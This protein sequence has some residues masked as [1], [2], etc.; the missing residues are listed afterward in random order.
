MASA[1]LPPALEDRLA[2]L[3]AR[4]WRL[5]VIRGA[6]RFVAAV[7]LLTTFLLLLDVA[8]QL[9]IS[10]RCGLQIV[11]LGLVSLLAWRLVVRPWQAAAVDRGQKPRSLCDRKINRGN[12]RRNQRLT[13]GAGK[14]GTQV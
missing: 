5:G 14:Q 13:Y 3:A 1:P 8:F 10:A 11:W 9:P 6:C 2:A 12:R 4:V 7:L